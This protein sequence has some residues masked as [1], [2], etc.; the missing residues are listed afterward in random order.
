MLLSDVIA[1]VRRYLSDPVGQRN[2]VA[3]HISGIMSFDHPLKGIQEGTIVSSGLQTFYVSDVNTS[4]NTVTVHQEQ[5]SAAL[6]SPGAMVRVHPRVTDWDAL[7]SV[8]DELVALSSPVNGLF[9]MKT[10]DLTY[11]SSLTGYNFSAADV[12]S[13]YE[14]RAATPGPREEWPRLPSGSGYRLDR[15]AP[16]SDFAAGQALNIFTPGF[17]GYDLRVMYK[18]AFGKFAALADDSAT[19][20]GLLDSTVS[21][22]MVGSAIRLMAGREIARNLTDAQGDTRRASE[23]PA[24]AVANSVNGLRILRQQMIM[25]EAARL[26]SM[27]PM[28][29]SD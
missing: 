23:V 13:I 25:E 10:V 6:L 29:R 19:V 28:Q 17:Q 8:N 5:G 26:T 18:A 24:G 11:S 9:Q 15:S 12:Q 22:V 20:C 21:L 27:Y 4:T 1:G 14:I 7:Q 2:Y 16:T 3:T